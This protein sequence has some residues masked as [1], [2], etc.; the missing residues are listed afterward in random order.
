MTLTD[1]QEELLISLTDGWEVTFKNGHYSTVKD[2]LAGAKLWPST[3]YGLYDDGYVEKL[4]NG[5]YT[6]SYDGKRQIRSEDK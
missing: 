3:F 1:A 5:N 4:E 6:I 2:N